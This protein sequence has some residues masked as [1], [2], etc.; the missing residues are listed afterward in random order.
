MH[1]TLRFSPSSSF[2][3]LALLWI[4]FFAANITYAQQPFI[5]TWK[6]DNAG[7]SNSTS[8]TI[9]AFGGGYNYEVDWNNDGTYDQSGITGIVTHD[10][11]VAGTYN[12]R[13]RGA[14]PAP[15]FNNSGD[16]LKLLDI[17]QWGDQVWTNTANAF[18]GCA[19]LQIS[20]TDLANMGSVTNMSGMFRG[21]S[22]L[23]GPTN[24]GSWNTANVTDMSNMFAQSPAFNQP[25]GSWNTANVTSMSQMF[26]QATAFNQ[27][28]GNWNTTNVTNMQAM[29]FLATAFNQPIGTWNTGNVTNMALMFA[30][31]SAFNQPIGTWNTVKVTNMSSMFSNAAAFNQP[32]G[33]WNTASV[34]NM[35]QMFNSASAFNQ[36]IGIWNT[37]NVTNMGV[38]FYLAS[39][40]NY[41]LST[42]N[43]TNVTDMHSIFNQATAFNQPISNW[44]VANVS[45][46]SGMFNAAYAFNQPL[47][48]WTLKAGVNLSYFLYLTGVNCDNYSATLIG[49]SANP[50]TPNSLSMDA[51]G[52][53]YGTNAVAAR[54]NLTTTKGWTITG[55]SPSGVACPAALPI[56]LISFNG[57]QQSNGVLLTWQTASEQNNKGFY[58]ERSNDTRNWETLGFVAGKGTSSEE[59]DYS[60]LDEKPLFPPHGGTQGGLYYRLRQMDFDGKEELSKVV[61]VEMKN[62]GVVRVFPNPVSNGELTL[63]FPEN[64]EEEIAVQLFNP[65]GQMLRSTKVNNLTTTLDVNGLA[66]GIYSLQVVSSNKIFIEKILVNN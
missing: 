10:F 31:A 17:G 1:L 2:L 36:P 33:T 6:T 29:F 44:N 43:T 42:W 65:A 32:I 8:I 40:F 41:P 34:T 51:F 61:S 54:T 56:E 7:T 20:A 53:Q 50:L 60:F 62:I 64:T 30:G 52:R 21:C 57:K 47:D 25:I 18:Y 13:I 66:S 12:I 9:P 16:R 27:P 49:W 59:Q 26:T 19:N 48:T 5:T 35:F 28:I 4:A 3:R 45:D 39:A 14:F 15:F 37:A 11:G 38:M 63:L 24:I 23:N 58:I 46:M 55:D 22:I